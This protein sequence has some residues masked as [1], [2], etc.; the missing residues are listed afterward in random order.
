MDNLFNY[1]PHPPMDMNQLRDALK[2]LEDIKF[3]LNES[4]IVAMTD[5]QGMITYVNERLCKISRYSREELIGQ[6]HRI[7]NSKLHPPQFFKDMWQTIGRGKVWKGEIRN[8]AKDGSFY[9]VDTTIVPFLNEKNKPYQY[10]SIRNDITSRKMMEEELRKNEEKYRLITE[11]SMDLISIVSPGGRLKYVSPS[12]EW[13]L[14]YLPSEMISRDLVDFVHPD[15]QDVMKEGFLTICKSRKPF[16]VEYRLRKTDSDFSLVEVKGNPV[17]DN[18]GNIK[19]IVM[20]S[21]D[22]TE[23]KK[24]EETIFYLAYHDSLTNL[25][26]RRLFKERLI[27]E[28]HYAKKFYSKLA[29][30]YIDMDRFKSINDTLGHDIGDLVLQE[31]ASRI[32]GAIRKRDIVSRI[33]GDEFTLLLPDLYDKEEAIT[34]ASR[35]IQ[36]FRVPF[37]IAGH[38]FVLSPSLGIAF[39]PQHGITADD[40]LKRADIALYYVKE[41]GRGYYEFYSPDMET[42]SLEQLLLE[43]ELR[44]ALEKEQ[45]ELYYQP[46][47]NIKTGKMIG[48][49]TL[50]RWVHPQLGTISPAKFIPIT[51]ETGLIVPLGEWILRKA[52]S[53]NKRWQNQGYPP[54]SISV[55]LSVLQFKQDNIV[56][57]IQAILHETELDPCW[58]ELEITESVLM[59]G[60][61]DAIAKLHHLKQLGIHISIDDFGTGYSSL[62]YL[63]S[64]PVDTLKIDSSFVRDLDKDKHGQAIVTAIISMANTLKLNVIAEGIETEEQLAVLNQEGCHEGQGYLFSRPVTTDRIEIFLKQLV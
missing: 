41:H 29:V 26:N 61:H 63:K 9:W 23:R 30:M 28:L 1:Y 49:E 6:D 64:F 25:P 42:R 48:M 2:E 10:V 8:R 37:E 45:F 35:I 34:V 57:R 58:L 55:N 7:L 17:L 22:I 44:M 15:D 36:S 38:R 11:N 56:E 52:C 33:G 59:D 5:H 27:N 12:Y 53:Q 32:A 46:K 31:V 21:R 14:G 24:A 3:A 16:Q 51:E 43:N 20:V 60:S 47:I 39:Y 4:S 13:I 54:V 50:I 62:S 18:Q 40:L 19:D